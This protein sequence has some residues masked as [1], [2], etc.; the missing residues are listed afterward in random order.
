MKIELLVG[1]FVIA[2]LLIFNYAWDTHVCGNRAAMMGVSYTYGAF[3]G[4]MVKVNGD[5]YVPMDSIRM[6]LK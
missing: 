2:S 4:C 5:H 6:S 1:V 3:A